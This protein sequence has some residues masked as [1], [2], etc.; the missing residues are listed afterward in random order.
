MRMR[1]ASPCAIPR[2]AQSEAS[3]WRLTCFDRS[4]GS[5]ESIMLRS[6]LAATGL[7]TLLVPP[8]QQPT[9]PDQPLRLAIAGLVHG[10]VSGFLKGAQGRTDV[11]IVG[12]YDP[13]AELLKQYGD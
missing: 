5:E 4:A 1:C 6:I 2:P 11:Q 8:A 13:D 10:H 3:R 9:S 12:I 7:V